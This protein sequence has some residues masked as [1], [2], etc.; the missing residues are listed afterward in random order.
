VTILE[1]T[2][3]AVPRAL[4]DIARSL[5]RP[6]LEAAMQRHGLSSNDYITT[7]AD[8]ADRSVSLGGNAPG[9]ARNT[10]GCAAAC[11]I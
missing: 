11:P 3:P 9:I 8:R 6:A 4:T 2:H 5:Y 1:A 7:S 10:F